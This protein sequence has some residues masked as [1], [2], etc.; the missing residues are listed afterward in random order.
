[1]NSRTLPSVAGPAIRRGQKKPGGGRAQALTR[2][3][4]FQVAGEQVLDVLP[5]GREQ[6]NPPGERPRRCSWTGPGERGLSGRRAPWSGRA[7][8][9][10]VSTGRRTRGR[11]ATW[12]RIPLNH[13][14]CR[15][16]DRSAEKASPVRHGCTEV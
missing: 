10:G 14:V 16:S 1:M 4:V 13:R 9:W 8:S 12:R 7:L 6:R 3:F 11:P 15:C 5:K 2:F